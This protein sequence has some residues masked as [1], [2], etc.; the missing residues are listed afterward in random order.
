MVEASTTAFTMPKAAFLRKWQTAT[1]E[2]PHFSSLN[3]DEEESIKKRKRDRLKE[4]LSGSSDSPMIQPI[5]LT[6]QGGTDTPRVQAK[7]DNLF[8]GM[9]SLD[10]ILSSGGGRED[11]APASTDNQKEKKQADDSWFA[12]EKQQIMENY[13]N[14][15]QEMLGT[16]QLEQENDPD[17]VPKNAEAMIKSVLK[18]EMDSE[19]EEARERR[20]T[21][22]LQEYETTQRQLSAETDISSVEISSG[23]Q[24]LMDESEAEFQRQESSR[25]E[26]EDFLKYEQEAK[27]TKDIAKP[28]KDQDLDQWALDRLKE[29]AGERG[30][31]DGDEMIRDILQENVLGLEKEMKKSSKKEPQSLKEWQMYR[32]IATKLGDETDVDEQVRNKLN[33]WKE[34]TEKENDNRKNS[35]LSRGP[36]LPFPWQESQPVQPPENA[37]VDK[38]SR[39]EARK[40]INRMSIEALESL[41]KTV[42][43]KRRDTLQKEIDFL[44]SAM[45]DYLDVDESML[46]DKVTETIPVDTSDLFQQYTEEDYDDSSISTK[47]WD[48]S[49]WQ[50]VKASTLPDAPSFSS[51]EPGDATPPDT[52]FF[53]N[54]PGIDPAIPPPNTPFFAGSAE[55]E[56]FTGDSKLGT[57]EDQ[58]LEA[59]Y[60]RA[61]ARTAQEREAIRSQWEE[62]QALEKGK[63][64]ESGLSNQQGSTASTDSLKYNIS[65]V[66]TEGG[67]FDAD[68]ILATIGPRP[69][70]QRSAQ[71]PRSGD[72]VT[73]STV[74][75]GDVADSLYRAVSAVGGGRYRDDPKSDAAT[76]ASYTEFLEREAEVRNSMDNENIDP[77]ENV[78]AQNIGDGVEY[79]EEVLSSLGSRPRPK[80]ARII[81]PGD[82]SDRGGALASEEEIEDDTS[83][84]DDFDLGLM[85]EWLRKESEG[86]NKPNLGFRGSE[87]G[88]VFD[89]TDYEHNT[90]QLAE[91]ERRRAGKTRSMGI[92]ISDVLGR[93]QVTSDDYAEYNFDNDYFRERQDS[94]GTES[95]QNR[96]KNLLEYRE[97]NVAEL[98]VLMDHKDSVYSTGV[99]KYLPRINKPFKDFG[100]VF[101]VEGVLADLTG[102]HL[103]AWNKVAEEYGFGAPNLV[104]VRQASVIRAEFA[105][106]DV[107]G[108]TDDFLECKKI[109]ESHRSAFRSVFDNWAKEQGLELGK[110]KQQDPPRGTFAIDEIEENVPETALVQKPATESE[111]IDLVSKA[112]R[113]TAKIHRLESPT[114]EQI[115]VAATLSPDIA[116]SELFVWTSDPLLV[117]NLVTT[118]RKQLRILQNIED[119]PVPATNR[120]ARPPASANSR[121]G[122]LSQTDVMELHYKAWADVARSRGYSEPEPTDVLAAF[123]FNEPA[124]AAQGFGW[125]ENPDELQSISNEFQLKLDSLGAP[126]PEKPKLSVE[127]ESN[128]ADSLVTD[129]VFKVT[130]DA[131]SATANRGSFAQPDNEQVQFA[132][133][134]GPEDAIMIGFEWTSDQTEARKLAEIYREEL[135]RRRPS[136]WPRSDRRSSS[137]TNT[138]LPI[139]PSPVG[140]SPDDVFKAALDA[141]T[142]T[143]QRHNCPPPDNDQVQFALTVGPEE[144]ILYGF[145]WSDDSETVAAIQ[146][147]YKS[148]LA[149][150]RTSWRNVEPAKK[151]EDP[152]D[153]PLF[154]LAPGVEKWIKSLSSV[155][156]QCGVISYLERDQLDALLEFSGISDLIDTDKRVC[157][158]NGYLTDSDAMLGAA[159]RL[160]RR[161]DHCVIFD[162]SPYAAVAAHEIEMNCVG[163]IGIYPRYELLS[164]DTTAASFDALTAMNIRRLF[165]ERIYDQPQV[166]LQ[167]AQPG[168]Q[169]K[170]RTGLGE[171]FE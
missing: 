4:L 132:M 12:A 93:S 9:P 28:E 13:E 46:E 71:T 155:E 112:W 133:T 138:L 120:L 11:T 3:D 8:D 25:L 26:I 95:F 78:D 117:D 82:F 55:G 96:K 106:K 38:Q 1:S 141:W 27:S 75:D 98:N 108:W 24:K 167:Q 64:D 168:P 66:M 144:A 152:E 77:A 119:E 111:R 135:G 124:V 42:D 99:S 47:E 36:R 74:D 52:P 100:A 123:S 121:S 85:P 129:E 130:F 139:S 148:E 51:E 118:Y 16:L 83:D 115:V 57:M 80:R 163:L 147:T 23:V 154:Q 140:P 128:Q 127:L 32:S 143:A 165:G 136:S 59:M 35:G 56:T 97:L 131:W 49:D 34:Y 79:A 60:R 134:V 156:M 10:D 142:A 7:F 20:I 50:S 104:D 54:E 76:R 58:K 107:F 113:A 116:V 86:E 68:A 19:I 62:F 151:Q 110:Y 40:E 63:R 48:S 161:P 39:I 33:S 17:S 84:D 61:G 94:W 149:K 92:D 29:M 21:E 166:D 44:K 158:S 114:D 69:S 103:L 2:V 109:A 153:T 45:V 150:R 105:V 72:I 30:D 87:M 146:E 157:W 170:T 18:Q 53:S 81:D 73:D 6:E 137:Q 125:T 90:R 101:R 65:D 22:M 88:N 91:Y 145:V 102:L 67:D 5:P 164:A 162:A 14:I 15:L 160:E 70:R 89:D 126:K 43:E 122:V 171:D 41:L 169:R 37:R 31:S 159:L